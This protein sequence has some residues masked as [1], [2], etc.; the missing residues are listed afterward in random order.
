MPNL[1]A[2]AV[3]GSLASVL[4]PTPSW[5]QARDL[6]TCTGNYNYCL[7]LTRRAGEPP[8]RCEAAYQQ[9]MRTGRAPNYDNPRSTRPAD[10]DRR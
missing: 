10:V 3:A 1:F 6:S 9:C 4:A 8:A 5:A 7:E 2:L